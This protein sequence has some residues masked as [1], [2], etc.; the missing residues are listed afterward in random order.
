[1]SLIATI[2]RSI[3]NACK[4]I[5]VM[6]DWF[7]RITAQSLRKDAF[8]GLTGATIVLPQG[9]AFAA[10]AGLPPEYGFYTAMITPVIAALIGSSWHAVS[11]PTTAISALVF[12]AL[13]G[14]IQVGS[15]EFFQAA[16]VLALLVGIIQLLL[17]LARL[18]AL[19]NFVSHSVM[20]GFI[21]GAAIL[22]ALSQVRHALGVDLPRP[23][24]LVEYMRALVEVLPETDHASALLAFVAFMTAWLVKRYLPAW[25]NYLLALVVS[26]ALYLMLGDWAGNVATIGEIKS[27]IP[28]FSS[29][30]L[31]MSHIR[32]LA[33]PAF[34]IALVGLLEAM[35]VSRAI[36]MRSGQDIDAN[37]EFIGQGASNIVGSFFACYPGSASFTR[38]GLNYESGAQTPLSAILAA[39]FLFAILLFVAPYFSLVPIPA[40]AGVIIMVAWKLVDTREVIHILKL[41]KGETAIAGITLGVSLL[42]DL[43]FSIYCGV[44]LSIILFMDR[45]AHPRLSVGMPNADLPSRTFSPIAQTGAQPCPQMIIVGLD[46]PLFFGSVE[47]IRKEFRSYEKKFPQQTTMI[48]NIKGTGMIDLPA[49][50]LLIEEAKRRVKRGGQLYV[51]TKIPRTIRQLERFEV[52]DYIADNKVHSNK[53]YAIASAVKQLNQDKCAQCKLRAFLECPKG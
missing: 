26:V 29:P 47:A 53:V 39:V 25:P 36:A 50:E 5:F 31:S 16:V 12:G 11:G 44:I 18:G 42:V 6:P 30:A 23:S 46:G 8:A 1:M 48:F 19:V 37:R 9:V 15:I 17:G 49:A 14:K 34:A 21:T 43:E 28:A 51:Q 4:T 38:S 10:I 35:S 40:M 20:T 22:I 52:L 45:S 33:S 13:V 7:G 24:D 27:V 41:S 2:S 3:V 32:D